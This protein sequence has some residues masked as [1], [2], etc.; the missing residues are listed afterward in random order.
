M[1]ILTNTH[2]STDMMIQKKY[3]KSKIQVEIM[4]SFLSGQVSFFVSF[5]LEHFA[6]WDIKGSMHQRRLTL[7]HGL[8]ILHL[9]NLLI[10]KNNKLNSLAKRI[11]S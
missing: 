5:R 1:A 8:L 11:Y 10:C 9:L 3:L 6:M 7:I 4:K 2:A